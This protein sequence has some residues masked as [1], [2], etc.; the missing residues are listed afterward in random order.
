MLQI[1]RAIP[2][3]VCFISAV[4][5]LFLQFFPNLIERNGYNKFCETS[6]FLTGIIIKIRLKASSLVDVV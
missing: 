1:Y 3:R 2:R 4:N 5:F 6:K